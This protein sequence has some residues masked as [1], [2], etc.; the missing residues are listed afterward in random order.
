M[1]SY[2]ILLDNTLHINLCIYL[3]QLLIC[4]EKKKI[5]ICNLIGKE[6]KLITV[7]YQSQK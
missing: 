3:K 5:D 6:E 7:C 2:H 4:I 1:F